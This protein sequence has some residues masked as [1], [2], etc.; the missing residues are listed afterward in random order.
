MSGLRKR[1]VAKERRWRGLL[2]Q[3]K[4]SGLT[5]RAFCDREGHT[6][7][8]FQWW[9]GEI[10]RRDQEPIPSEPPA[11]AKSVRTA[12]AFLPVKLSQPLVLEERIE[13]VMPSGLLVRIGCEQLTRVLDVLESRS[14]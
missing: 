8:S 1:D 3:Q 14:C 4:R 5:V 12:P 13:I 11:G 6:E 2:A 7:S 10:A 9:R